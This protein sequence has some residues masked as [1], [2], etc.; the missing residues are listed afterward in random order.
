MSDSR[1]RAGCAGRLPGASAQRRVHRL[2][3]HAFVR[4]LWAGLSVL[5]F[6]LDA[7]AQIAVHSG[8]PPTS[9]WGEEKVVPL[10]TIGQFRGAVEYD[11]TKQEIRI[12]WKYR[13]PQT[14]H[15]AL[16]AFQRIALPYWPTDVLAL[17]PTTLCVAGKRP[18]SDRTVIE[19]IEFSGPPTLAALLE[20][21][22]PKPT[23][24]PSPIGSRV[25]VFDDAVVGKDMVTTM[26]VHRGRPGSILVQFYDSGDVYEMQLND[27]AHAL[28]FSATPS[29]AAQVEL[30]LQKRFV[31]FFQDHHKELGFVYCFASHVELP[32]AGVAMLVD[33]EES[34]DGVLDYSM[35]LTNEEW[36]D[37]GFGCAEKYVG[38]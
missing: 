14:N 3:R 36:V 10:L 16:E 38:G 35:W 24:S 23:I 8:I 31:R 28:V 27:G 37:M 5:A 22:K 34:L 1:D 26:F 30:A 7:N 13:E 21:K 29:A 20:S 6:G 33:T 18:R 9:L 4:S 15:T 11:T 25:T 32:G 2:S 17:G 12:E 19:Q